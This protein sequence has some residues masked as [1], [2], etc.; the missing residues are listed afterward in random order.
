MQYQPDIHTI[1]KTAP[2]SYAEAIAQTAPVRD[3]TY[4]PTSGQPTTMYDQSRP[5]MSGYSSSTP[6]Y[7]HQSNFYSN[8]PATQPP[9]NPSYVAVEPSQ[10]SYTTVVAPCIVQSDALRMRDE[11]TFCERKFAPIIK[12]RSLLSSPFFTHKHTHRF[13][14]K[15]YIILD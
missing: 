14:R 11:R 8:M 9:Y 3:N 5:Q 13:A 2:P 15:I 7:Q 10:Q 4:V 12:R 1:S 6:A